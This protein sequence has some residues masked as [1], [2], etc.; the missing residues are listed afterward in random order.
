MKNRGREGKSRQKRNRGMI[1][2]KVHLEKER[3]GGC[4]LNPPEKKSQVKRAT[5]TRWEGRLAPKLPTYFLKKE[6]RDESREKGP[7]HHWT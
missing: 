6:I 1:P 5:A 4:Y 7:V 3:G 2:I